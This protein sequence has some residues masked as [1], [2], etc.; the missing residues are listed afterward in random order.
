M[1]DIPIASDIVGWIQGLGNS[2]SGAD[3]REAMAYER[4]AQAQKLAAMQ[5]AAQVYGQYRPQAQ[6][7]RINALSNISTAYQPA[8]NALATLYGGGTGQVPYAPR[9]AGYRPITAGGAP[10][11]ASPYMPAPTGAAA[12]AVLDNGNSMRNPPGITERTVTPS[13]GLSEV[14]RF[15]PQVASRL[16]S[17]PAR[18]TTPPS[19]STERAQ[20]PS[21]AMSFITPELMRSSAGVAP[22]TT[23]ALNRPASSFNLAAAGEAAR[24]ARPNPTMPT[25]LPSAPQGLP[26]SRVPPLAGMGGAPSGS[27]G[28]VGGVS[29]GVAAAT[30]LKP[31]PQISAQPA[32]TAAPMV[33]PTGTTGAAGV[34]FQPT[35]M[36]NNPFGGGSLSIPTM[37]AMPSLPAGSGGAGGGLMPLPPIEQ[38]LALLAAGNDMKGLV[39]PTV[40]SP[41]EGVAKAQQFAPQVASRMQPTTLKPAPSG[42]DARATLTAQRPTAA[43]QQVTRSQGMETIARLMKGMS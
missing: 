28:V 33:A 21:Q 15:A 31:G 19:A 10:S 13:Q 37:A 5:Q 27:T 34:S 25:T 20:T 18:P 23:M 17:S 2:L 1:A 30:G 43:P 29:P 39:P 8:N 22:R 41:A 11:T 36:L 4:A 14:A 26:Q 24:S 12:R 16:P 42:A 9:P 6:Q 38:I 40:L 35:Q 7:A 32:S 3:T